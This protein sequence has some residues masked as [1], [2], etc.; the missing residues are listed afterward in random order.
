MSKAK[1]QRTLADLEVLSQF[2][3]MPM[4]AAGPSQQGPE[5]ILSQFAQMQMDGTGLGADASAQLGIFLVHPALWRQDKIGVARGFGVKRTAFVVN[6]A[7]AYVQYDAVGEVDLQLRF[8]GPS[9]NG[10]PVRQNYK[11]IFDNDYSSAPTGSGPY[12]KIGPSRWRIDEAPPEQWVSVTT[13]IKYV[14]QMR[15]AA[16]DPAIKANAD[17]TL[18]TLSQYR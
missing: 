7:E 16:R 3:S 2:Q 15:D 13:A 14:N 10:N 5:D 9:A 12:D 18:A 1:A 4:Q 11:L 8:T 6:K 17:K